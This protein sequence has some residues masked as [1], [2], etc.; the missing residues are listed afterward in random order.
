MDRSDVNFDRREKLLAKNQKIMSSLGNV[1]EAYVLKYVQMVKS[2]YEPGQKYQ[3]RMSI[4][5][6]TLA[7]FYRVR[8]EVK[9]AAETFMQTF[10]LLKDCDQLFSGM[11]L[12]Q[13]VNSYLQCGLERQAS[14]TLKVAKQ[15]F[16]G[17]MEYLNYVYDI[18]DFRLP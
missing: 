4:P 17:S 15:F 2:T 18:N 1:D 11:L 7:S 9:K 8:G 13:A 10:E 12:I 5:M 3:Y 14:E 6:V 16:V